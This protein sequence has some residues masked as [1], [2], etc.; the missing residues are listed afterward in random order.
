MPQNA[1]VRGFKVTTSNKSV[2]TATINGNYITIKAKGAGVAKLTSTSLGKKSNDKYATK[3]IKVSVKPNKVS[4]LKKSSVKKNSFK[5]SWKKQSGV[6]G[7]EIQANGKKYK[8][9]KTSYTIKRLKS[10]KTYKVVIK[11]YKKTRDGTVY[12][13]S[14][15]IKI[16]T[17]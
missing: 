2:A 15:S 3:T 8:T 16:K 14:A 6:S 12:S 9:S 4:N 1:T 17:K 10:K 5:I 7:Y 11:S 13:N